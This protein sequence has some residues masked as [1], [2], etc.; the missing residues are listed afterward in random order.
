[1]FKHLLPNK[2]RFKSNPH[3]DNNIKRQ[4]FCSS[5]SIGS[6]YHMEHLEYLEEEIVD[7]METLD[8]TRESE[9]PYQFPNYHLS[10]ALTT[11]NQDLSLDQSVKSE[12]LPPGAKEFRE[13]RMIL[14]KDDW[15]ECD[16]VSL[17][18]CF[19]LRFVGFL[20]KGVKEDRTR[21]HLLS[22]V[23]DSVGVLIGTWVDAFLN[24]EEESHPS[25]R[26]HLGNVF[27][28]L[29]SSA[30]LN[31]L[32]DL[33]ILS[34][35]LRTLVMWRSHQ[36]M[37]GKRNSSITPLDLMTELNVHGIEVSA[38]RLST[39]SESRAYAMK[40]FENTWGDA[41][42]LYCTCETFTITIS[43]AGG[44][45]MFGLMDIE[46]LLGWSD[47][48]QSRWVVGSIIH[49]VQDHSGPGMLSMQMYSDILRWGDRVLSKE[50]NKGYKIIKHYE[51]VMISTAQK[52]LNDEANLEILNDTPNAILE[53]FTQ[54]GK[55]YADELL[56]IA[57]R[58]SP[59][60][61][62]E[63]M[64]FFRFW[65][66]PIINIREGLEKL[67][68]NCTL[69][70]CIDNVFTE[71]LASDM[72]KV[73]ISHYYWDGNEEGRHQWPKGSRVEPGLCPILE[74]HIQN[75]TFPSRS[76]MYAIGDIWHKIKYDHIFDEDAEIPLLDLLGDKSHSMNKDELRKLLKYAKNLKM[77]SPTKKLIISILKTK[78]INPIKYLRYIN[79][80]GFLDDDLIIGLRGKEREIK[81]EGRFFSLMSFALRLYFVATEYLANKYILPL[82]PEITMGLS[83]TDTMKMMCELTKGMSGSGQHMNILIHLDYE[84]WN[85]HQRHEANYPIFLQVDKAFG[86]T[87][88][89]S[90]THQIFQKATIYYVERLDKIV[91]IEHPPL[92]YGWKGQGGGLE[93]LRQKMWTVVGAL[94]LRRVGMHH[95]QRFSSIMQGDNQVVI[96]KYKLYSEVNTS[97]RTAEVRRLA[98]GGKKILETIAKYSGKLGLITKI[99]ETWI[100]SSLLVYGKYPIIKGESAGMLLK[101]MSRLYSTSND[102][103]PSI[104]NVLSSA[105]TTG[106]T[107]AQKYSNV[108][109][110]LIITYWYACLTI[111]RYMRYDPMVNEGM[112]RKLIKITS[113]KRQGTIHWNPKE[114]ST[115]YRILLDI[116]FRDSV[117]G[118]LGGCSPLRFFIRDF[119][120]PLCESMTAYRC[121]LRRSEINSIERA[122]FTNMMHPPIKSGVKARKRLLESPYSLSLYTAPHT[123]DV[124]K[125]NT[126]NELKRSGRTWIANVDL[127]PCLGTGALSED[128][129]VEK[130]FTITPC[131]PN[132]LSSVYSNTLY[133]VL[134][135]LL[136]RVTGP[137]TILSMC[138]GERQGGFWSMVCQ[139]EEKSI[140]SA[141]SK[142]FSWEL[143]R[144]KENVCCSAKHCQKL[145][146]ASWGIPI[147]GVTVP[148]PAEQVEII[149]VRNG[150]CAMCE[151]GNFPQS[152]YIQVVVNPEVV[153]DPKKIFSRGPG[154]PYLGSATVEKRAVQSE[155]EATSDQPPIK[156]LLKLLD[157]IDW[158]VNKDTGVYHL[159]KQVAEGVTECPLIELYNLRTTTSGCALHRYF[160]D[161]NKR[162]GFS[163]CA[164][165]AATHMVLSGDTLNRLNRE[166]E[167]YVIVF[168]SIFLYV[169]QVITERAAINLPI[170]PAYHVHFSCT[171]CLIPAEEITLKSPDILDWGV[172]T[173]KLT[174]LTIEGPLY[175]PDLPQCE[176]KPSTGY[177]TQ[178]EVR[179]KMKERHSFSSHPEKWFIEDNITKSVEFWAGLILASD[180]MKLKAI[181]NV[182]HVS[183][184]TSILNKVDYHAVVEM[185][186]LGSYLEVIASFKD[187]AREEQVYDKPLKRIVA[188]RWSAANFSAG[189]LSAVNHSYL[190]DQLIQS[191]TSSTFSFLIKT[192]ELNLSLWSLIMTNLET[193]TPLEISLILERMR[194]LIV[195]T[196]L[197]TVGIEERL[198]WAVDV[199]GRWLN[200]E[201]LL[202][203]YGFTLEFT[204]YDFKSMSSFLTSTPC[205]RI[206]SKKGYQSSISTKGITVWS[207]PEG[208][209]VDM[210]PQDQSYLRS[211]IIHFVRLIPELTTA[212]YKLADILKIGPES[213]DILVIGDGNGGFSSYIVR[214]YPQARVFFNSLLEIETTGNETL[215]PKTAPSFLRLTE[216]EKS[217]IINWRECTSMNSDL[218][219]SSWA[220]DTHAFLKARL[221]NCD[222]IISDIEIYDKSLYTKYLNNIAQFLRLCE[223]KPDLILKTHWPD[224]DWLHSPGFYTIRFCVSYG[225]TKVIRSRFSNPGAGEIYVSCQPN[226][227]YVGPPSH[228]LC[229]D[230]SCHPIMFNP[231]LPDLHDQ[232]LSLS[233]DEI[234][235]NNLDLSRNFGIL[236]RILA[237]FSKI[238]EGMSRF[239]EDYS[240]KSYGQLSRLVIER[241]ISY[242]TI[243]KEWNLG[244]TLVTSISEITEV[245]AWMMAL[246][247]IKAFLLKSNGLY[248][249]CLE[250][251]NGGCIVQLV[252][253]V[254]PGDPGIKMLVYA[255]KKAPLGV[256][257]FSTFKRLF[258]SRSR[259]LIQE[260]LRYMGG[261]FWTLKREDPDNAINNFFSEM[262]LSTDS[263][264]YPIFSPTLRTTYQQRLTNQIM[265][266]FFD[267]SDEIS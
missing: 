9:R 118:G 131:M 261:R 225:L 21:Y 96:A 71:T 45:K 103:T 242:V 105:F 177:F 46:H 224:T 161:R 245:T 252:K 134:E 91:D 259:T 164:F 149:G 172:P 181:L 27:N 263:S 199:L 16:P 106:L 79:T 127:N 233:T 40:K 52:K 128:L 140:L 68:L 49:G 198:T 265:R 250:M 208:F 119:P 213:K 215:S 237:R 120:D 244:D 92:P 212:W 257:N 238:P 228:E 95:N 88:V 48:V 246:S 179:I 206:E 157:T 232:I 176:I 137:S 222:L 219:N 266:L 69:S 155:C 153:S 98:A 144:W 89:F 82:F 203:S 43:E 3:R 251:I 182:Q 57:N 87:Q 231:N 13:R 28:A 136:N 26:V 184:L 211:P 100:S 1:M 156:R 159:L 11:K 12:E 17:F 255:G 50:G 163:A 102:A 110:P 210:S 125:R 18:M 84:K 73:L 81:L 75:N 247:L 77:A 170:F 256:K 41:A 24:I 54:D 104:T 171:D 135:G 42:I 145:R 216:E 220:E 221:F 25:F 248:Y 168:Q 178:G 44:R 209:F 264:Q 197:N 20:K 143:E 33:R 243:G 193:S 223:G 60:Q 29:T 109:L 235:P 114:S 239:G 173:R 234:I 207:W 122:V 23:P 262:Q 146:D 152:E 7:V 76:E 183:F 217:R 59:H 236:L 115:H 37:I 188:Q 205:T 6:R 187:T 51:G 162:G 67:H 47:M 260:H 132:F 62:L 4:Y 165:N 218:T 90:L 64:S 53:G 93:G 14:M 190:G 63:S 99:E 19:V 65:C 142:V 189:L 97:E 202:G 107:A 267:A 39:I 74:R 94:L 147:V 108:T 253:N 31:W 249:Q 130:L 61:L 117:L 38:E 121:L 204:P 230:M 116:L 66:H 78:K 101:V 36:M 258:L 167:N 160:S 111:G 180:G 10:V 34:D 123:K 15:K 154:T 166:S 80:F 169:Q 226:I 22:S 175:P 158:F 254:I 240:L 35:V 185:T 124:V 8:L 192:S 55:S 214:H 138:V 86:W 227:G 201:G 5:Y 186:I 83:G 32:D 151:K 200:R 174:P 196:D 56:T 113:G 148:H 191:D 70:K 30:Q 141:F 112:I 85:N 150:V 2:R 129:F 72:A 139:A 241:Y 126:A 229:L 194:L 195:P 58:M 133:G